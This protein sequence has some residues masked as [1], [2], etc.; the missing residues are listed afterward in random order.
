MATN[1]KTPPARRAVKP[2]AV[3]SPKPKVTVAKTM[4]AASKAKPAPAP[5][6]AVE[7]MVASVP[8]K[9]SLQA[10]TMP[11]VRSI[12]KKVIK[13]APSKQGAMKTALTTEKV[14]EKAKKTKLVRDSFTMPEPEYAV[15]GQVKR[16]CINAG[17]DIKKS[18]LLRIGVALIRDLELARLE[19]LLRNLPKLKSG[20]PKKA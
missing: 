3:A 18:E 7:T 15:L 17:V 11:A 4:A 5:A 13:S 19:E 12:V 9:K 2:A 10:A 6:L 16:A 8:V 1:V 20:R 14:K